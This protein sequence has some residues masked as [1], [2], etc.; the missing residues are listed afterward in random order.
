MQIRNKSVATNYSLTVTLLITTSSFGTSSV[1]AAAAG[2]D[3]FDFVDYVHP[4][5]D[6]CEYAV[7]PT[8]QAFAGEVQEVVIGDVDEE[9][10]GGGVGRL[11]TGHR[12]RTAGVFRPLFASF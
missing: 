2:G 3:R 11:S 9:L 10:R 8:L 7:A 4:F 5:N 1:H 12:Q 6:F